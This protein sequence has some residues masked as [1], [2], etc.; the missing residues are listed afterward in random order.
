MHIAPEGVGV[1]MVGV[2]LVAHDARR[3]VGAMVGNAFQV[4][5]DLKENNAR[6]DGALAVLQALDVPLAQQLDCL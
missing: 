4:R 6:V 5:Q 1:E 3:H 2:R